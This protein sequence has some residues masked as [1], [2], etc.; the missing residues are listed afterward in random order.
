[1]NAA[2]LDTDTLSHVMRK[3][4]DALVHAKAYLKVHSRFT[5]SLMTRYEILRG[6]KARGQL[7]G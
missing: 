2:L 4:P 7:R 3:H 6:L 5:S 1:M